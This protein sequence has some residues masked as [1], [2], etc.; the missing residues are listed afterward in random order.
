MGREWTGSRGAVEQTQ[1]ALTTGVVRAD[2]SAVGAILRPVTAR[3]LRGAAHR[4]WGAA[5]RQGAPSDEPRRAPTRVRGAVVARGAGVRSPEQRQ[6]A[7]G[8]ESACV[9]L[10]QPTGRVVPGPCSFDGRADPSPTGNQGVPPVRD[11]RLAPR[12]DW[13]GDVRGRNDRRSDAAASSGGRAPGEATGWWRT[14]GAHGAGR[15]TP[16]ALQMALF[17]RIGGFLVSA[18]GATALPE[19]ATGPTRPIGLTPER[20]IPTV[21]ATRADGQQAAVSPLP[22]PQVNGTLQPRCSDEDGRWAVHGGRISVPNTGGRT[23]RSGSGQGRDQRQPDASRGP[24]AWD[25]FA[26]RTTAERAAPPRAVR[27]PREGLGTRRIRRIPSSSR[28]YADLTRPGNTRRDAT[29]G[30]CEAPDRRVVQA[31]WPGERNLRGAARCRSVERAACQRPR[32]LRGWATRV[33]SPSLLQHLEVVAGA[34]STG[35]AWRS[36]TW[37]TAAQRAGTGAAPLTVLALVRRMMPVI[38]ARSVPV[39]LAVGQLGRTGAHA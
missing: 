1:Q 32:V 28:R 21:L 9:W 6:R 31:A 39:S 22:V 2:A 38:V 15:P 37:R 26:D 17:A 34:G 12:D 13:R 4:C 5:T 30:R 23:G 14:C 10:R 24:R 3:C 20:A 8:G 33:P 25:Q 35:P 29:C 19:V 7:Q 16:D 18:G 27:Y 11:G 36:P